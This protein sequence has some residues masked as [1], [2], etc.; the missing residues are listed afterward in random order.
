MTTLSKTIRK[1]GQLRLTGILLIAF[2][3][4]LSVII[5][6]PICVDGSY[7]IQTQQYGDSQWL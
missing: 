6:I 1:P 7:F 3:T 4:V 5:L 2:F